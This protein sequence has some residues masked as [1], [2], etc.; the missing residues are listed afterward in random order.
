M[1]DKEIMYLDLDGVIFNFDKAIKDAH[2]HVD[3]DMGNEKWRDLVDHYC[4]NK[5]SRIF[6]NLKLI[7]GAE[8]AVHILNREFNIYFL[9]TPMWNVPESF[10]DKRLA[11][12]EHFGE[13][14]HK[15]LILSHNKGL[16]MGKYLIDDRIKNGVENFKG[17]HIHFGSEKFPD[18]DAV[19]T[20]LF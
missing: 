2:P 11:L 3:I 20:Y 17:E 19:L 8:D 13:V 12:E 16:C 9:S 7:E 4:E 5:N 10:M 15:K 18:W 1:K 6:R 14:A